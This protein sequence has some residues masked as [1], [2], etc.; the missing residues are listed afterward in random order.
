MD[1]H[2]LNYQVKLNFYLQGISSEILSRMG[3]LTPGEQRN[4]EHLKL[5]YSLSTTD[6]EPPTLYLPIY[7]SRIESPACWQLQLQHRATHMYLYYKGQSK[8]P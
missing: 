7:K 3:I 2:W 6:F 5:K 4:T 1:N 8:T